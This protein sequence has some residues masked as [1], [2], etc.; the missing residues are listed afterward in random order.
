MV[1]FVMEIKY[2]VSVRIVKIKMTFFPTSFEFTDTMNSVH[3]FMY[4]NLS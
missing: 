2:R 4:G 1:T 3:E